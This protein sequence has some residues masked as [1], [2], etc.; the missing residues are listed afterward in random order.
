MF[1]MIVTAI[2]WLGM[3]F[4]IGYFIVMDKT[5][6]GGAVD[7]IH[8]TQVICDEYGPTWLSQQVP[9]NGSNC[10]LSVGASD[11]DRNR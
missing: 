10:Q 7:Y 6:S 2:G 11:A 5:K 9:A 8:W 4:A 1:S 3:A